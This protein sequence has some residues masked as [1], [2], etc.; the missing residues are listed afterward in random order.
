MRTALLATLPAAF[1]GA[2][3]IAEDIKSTMAGVG[4]ACGG[5]HKQ[6]RKSE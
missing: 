2:S 4:E 5:C 6:F 1:A 3:A